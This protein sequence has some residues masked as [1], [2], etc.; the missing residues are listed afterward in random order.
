MGKFSQLQSER[1]Q[2]AQQREAIGQQ[3]RQAQEIARVANERVQQAEKDA[4]FAKVKRDRAAG[5]FH[6]LKQKTPDAL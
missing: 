5:A 4:S 1:Q 3:M 6:R 2:L